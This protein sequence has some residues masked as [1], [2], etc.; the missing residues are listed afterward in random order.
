MELYKK[1]RPSDFGDVVSNK[2]TCDVLTNLIKSGFP[3]AV[4]L[5]GPSGSGKTTIARILATKLG[6]HSF[7]YFEKNAADARGIDD[8]REVQRNA[9]VKSMAGNG[10]MFVFDEAHK[11]TGDAQTMLLKLLEDGPEGVYFVLCT[12]DPNKLIKT[13]HTRCTTFQTTK[14]DNEELEQLVQKVAA[15]E[16]FKLKSEVA[17]KIAESAE[18]SARQ[19]LVTLEKV[20]Q[21]TDVEDQFK[22]IVNPETTKQT[23]DLCRA[24]MK[25][26]V[27]WKEIATILKSINDEP[28]TVRRIV[29]GY[30]K[31]VLLNSGMPIAVKVINA[32]QYDFFQSGEAGLALACYNVLHG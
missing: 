6:I 15:K 26:G 21:I 16:K 8:V 24:M 27:T 3:K 11:L 2:T 5:S 22:A 28:E 1:H 30:Y 17:E 32:F 23:I 31:A 13:I 18:G 19:A 29:L 7:D 12:T 25:K 14:L 4:L 20:M 10:K 9:S